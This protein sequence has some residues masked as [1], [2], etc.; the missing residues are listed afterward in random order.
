MTDAGSRW[1]GAHLFHSGD[2]DPLINDVVDPVTRE[3]AADGTV[4]RAFFLRYWEGGQHVR[5]RLEVPDPARAPRVHDLVRERAAAHFAAHPSPPV[6]AAAYRAFAAA[7]A[8]G[9]RR[10]S[11]DERLRPAGSVA[12]I[13]YRPEYEAYGDAACVAAAERHFAESSRLA[14]DVLRAGTEMARRAA[15]GLAA[16]T[17]AAAAC[18]PDLPAAAHRLATA[19][20]AREDRTTHR[21]A[22]GA[23]QARAVSD[24]SVSAEDWRRREGALLAQTR[25]LWD[26]PGSGGDLLATWAASVCALRDELAALHAA[27]RCAPRD[28]GSPHALLA[29]AAPPE[30]R[31]VSLILMR[32]VHLFH[33]RLGLRAGTERHVSYLAVR[34]LAGLADSRR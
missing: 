26:T 30:R 7:M 27:G 4:R 34:A 32:C 23:G 13:G 5:L 20:Q 3:L 33:N 24:E 8:A 31:T 12:F 29:L 11:Y 21:L 2:L 14:L 6:D 19:R 28:S 16:L 18:E 17:V 25:R 10:T 15:I 22:A 9:E 1:I